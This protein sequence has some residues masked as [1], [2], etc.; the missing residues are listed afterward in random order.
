MTYPQLGRGERALFNPAFMALV[1]ARAVR[2]HRGHDEHCPLALAVTA[3]VMALQPGIRDLLP[4]NTNASVAKWVDD[5]AEI[6]VMMA[7]NTTALAPV[8]RAG[9]LFATQTGV[10]TAHADATVSLVSPRAIPAQPRGSA[11]TVLSIQKAAGMLGRWLPT[12]GSTATTLT[13]L[14]VRP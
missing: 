5:H 1:C 13:L 14:G 4:K 12:A 7:A 10:L 2:E 8:A 9:L 6:R 11:P 3:A